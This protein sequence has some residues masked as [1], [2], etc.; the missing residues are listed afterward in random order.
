MAF[1][2]PSSW[3]VQTNPPG[4]YGN[5]S[6]LPPQVLEQMQQRFDAPREDPRQAT[7]CSA[8]TSRVQ[9]IVN[10]QEALQSWI[11]QRFS[12]FRIVNT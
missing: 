5:I 12:G 1:S 6:T 10:P 8:T 9:G 3:Y 2:Y 4:I 11:S 7:H